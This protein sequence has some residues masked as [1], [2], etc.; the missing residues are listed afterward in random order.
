MS[1]GSFDCLS[2]LDQNL[3]EDG[4][5][6]ER[7]VDSP[8][9]CFVALRGWL[10]TVLGF[11]EQ[12]HAIPP[13]PMDRQG[14]GEI[15]YRIDRLPENRLRISK[16]ELSAMHDIRI[17]GNDGAHPQGKKHRFTRANAEAALRN[18]GIIRDWL[19]RQYVRPARAPRQ[20]ARSATSN[21]DPSLRTPRI[22]ETETKGSGYRW[23]LAAGVVL[24][25]I[26]WAFVSRNS[27]SR[28]ASQHVGSDKQIEDTRRTERERA[29]NQQQTQADKARRR[30]EQ[31]RQSN[32][33]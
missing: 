30:Q 22:S 3:C 32:G 13:L 31:L 11:L 17:D 27:A 23:K 24:L 19:D 28:S 26:L 25:L 14:K 2:S 20:V 1:S 16:S 5:E 29:A 15:Q 6:A 33:R 9:Y 18:A 4:N 7:L 12:H 21:R 8:R 10:E